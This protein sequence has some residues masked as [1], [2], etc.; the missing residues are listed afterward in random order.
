MFLN[1]FPPN[2]GMSKTYIPCTI[3]T[4]KALDWKKICKLHFGAYVQ[5]Q[6]DRN[7]TNTIEEIKQGEICLGNTGNLQ[8]TYNLFLL[9]SG[10]KITRGQLNE[11]P[12]PK[13]VIKRVAAMALAKKH[14]ERLIFENCTGTM[15]NNILP[16]DKANEAFKKIDGNISGV[17]WEAEIQEQ[18]AHMPQINNNKYASLEGDGENDEN[19]DDQENDTKSTGVEN[20]GEITGVRHDEE[21]T[22]VGINNKRAGIKYEWG[23]TGATDKT[24]EMVL[25]EEAIEE[26]NWDIAEGTDILS[27]TETETEDTGKKKRDT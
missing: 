4:G 17:D 1:D 18:E 13:I 20:D 26:A 2:I 3:M 24:D 12:T 14:N 27:G 22:G 8:G 9:R 21:I 15:V 19:G 23:S 7:V 10:K 16:Y 5:V 25:I 11:V 6:K